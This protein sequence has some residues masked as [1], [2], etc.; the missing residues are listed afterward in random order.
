MV[1]RYVNQGFSGGEKKR[2]EILQLAVLE[3]EIAI[4]DETDSGLD[5][6]SLKQVAMRRGTADRAG[7]RR[8][9]DHALPADLELHHAGLR[10]RDDGRAYREVRRQ[11]ARARARGE[12]LRGYPQGAR[13]RG[14]PVG[15]AG[16]RQ[17]SG[18]GDR[19]TLGGRWTSRASGRTSRSCSARSRTSRSS[20]WTL[21]RRRRSRTQVIDAESDFYAHHNAN[22]H[23]G[24]Y[25][26]AEEATE[27]Y[28]GARASS[29]LH[30]CAGARDDRLHAWDDGVDEPRRVRAGPGKFLKEGD[31]IL[32]TEM[33]HHSNIVPWQLAARDT[34]A[35]LRYLPLTDDGLLDLSE[36]RLAPSPSGRSSSRD[37]HVELAR[38]APAAEASSIDAAHAVGALVLVDGAQLVPHVP[39]DVAELDCDFLTISGHKMLGPTASGGLYA[40]ARAPRGDGPVPGWR[41][42][43]RRGLPRSRRRGTTC[44][45]SSRPGP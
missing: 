14:E 44:R 9:A 26:L 17:R 1:N 45:T 27:L 10:P 7:P 21:R 13:P 41:A 24:L 12:G 28:E 3:P 25:L 37:R 32:L 6:D 15:D 43:D 36:P 33:E 39:V 2:N 8:A 11:G 16:R 40:Q 20:T 35:V 18:G 42:H 38:H 29:P 31:E 22:A 19:G 34:G 4:L 5:I 30:R 23:R